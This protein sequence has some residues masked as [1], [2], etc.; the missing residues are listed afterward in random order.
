MKKLGIFFSP[1]EG[2]ITATAAEEKAVETATEDTQKQAPES[3][4]QK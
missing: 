4:E 1:G 3:D 2:E